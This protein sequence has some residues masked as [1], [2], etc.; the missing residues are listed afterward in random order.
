MPENEK[1]IKVTGVH[2]CIKARQR[3]EKYTKL[4]KEKK[5]KQRMEAMKK[6]LKKEK[7]AK[8]FDDKKATEVA[9][10]D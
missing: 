9:T 3:D 10:N 2:T 4:M 6:N 5:G 1:F 7:Q 8:K